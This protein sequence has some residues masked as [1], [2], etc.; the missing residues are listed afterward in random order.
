MNY[1]EKSEF[2]LCKT[3]WDLYMS[4][5]VA[6]DEHERKQASYAMKVYMKHREGCAIC[7]KPDR[8]AI[9]EPVSKLDGSGKTTVGNDEAS[10]GKLEGNQQATE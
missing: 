5:S 7:T 9:D 10:G 2:Y 4:W 1:S 3:G 8:R 6:L